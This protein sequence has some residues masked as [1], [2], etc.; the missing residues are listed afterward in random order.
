MP[1]TAGRSCEPA[2]LDTDRAEAIARELG[3][4]GRPDAKVN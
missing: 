4:G 1:P 2:R 3:V